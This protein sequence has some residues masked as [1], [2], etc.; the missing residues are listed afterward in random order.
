MTFLFRTIA[1]LSLLC[2]DE[3]RIQT[4][5]I[6][7]AIHLQAARYGRLTHLEHLLFY[8]AEVDAQNE[9][10]NTALHVCA[11]YKQETAARTLLFR[12]IDRHIKNKA[13]QTAFQVRDSFIVMVLRLE[14]DSD[15]QFFSW[16]SCF[17][18]L[19][20]DLVR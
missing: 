10:G 5:D 14:Y 18:I 15:S 2:S 7:I 3:C 11:L 8:G 13:S 1:Q 16:S 17:L 4:C 9:A 12:G 6:L 19:Y 20:V